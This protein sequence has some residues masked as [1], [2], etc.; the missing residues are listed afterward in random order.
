MGIGVWAGGFA[1]IT[2][3][4]VGFDP[5]N[6]GKALTWL[7]GSTYGRTPEQSAP[8]ALALP[9]TPDRRARAARAGPAGLDDDTPRVLG[10][11]LERARLLLLGGAALVTSTA[12]RRSG[13]SAS[14]GWSP[15][16]RRVLWSARGTAVPCRRPPC[17]ARF[18]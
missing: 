6:T 1:I 14:S 9:F 17:S 16:T 7:S 4:I 13:S 12:G 11:P 15:R 2:F 8:V 3:I 18:W 5:W 10:V